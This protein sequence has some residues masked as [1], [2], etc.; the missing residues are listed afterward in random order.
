MQ[1]DY[2]GDG[3]TDVAVARGVNGDWFASY[4]SGGM[5][6]VRWGLGDSRVPADYD[7]DGTADVAIWR[8]SGTWLVQP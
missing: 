5:L 1:A 2:D 4:S 8:A 7:G 6:N 3:K